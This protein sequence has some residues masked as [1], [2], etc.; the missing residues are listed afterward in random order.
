MR[1]ES[2]DGGEGLRREERAS[3][4]CDATSACR[5]MSY[6]GQVELGATSHGKAVSIA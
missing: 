6:P 3:H 2:C 1:P 4:F 5:T